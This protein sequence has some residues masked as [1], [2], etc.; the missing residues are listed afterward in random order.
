MKVNSKL[1][2]ERDSFRGGITASGVGSRL[3]G[4]FQDFIIAFWQS[5]R[6][7]SSLT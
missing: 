6:Y 3:R 4:S 2:N 1:A 7:V 5:D